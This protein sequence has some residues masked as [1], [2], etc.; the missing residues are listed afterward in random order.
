MAEGEEDEEAV[1]ALLPDEAVLAEVGEHERGE[2]QC[3]GERCRRLPG[4]QGQAQQ[5]ECGEHRGECP[6]G[7]LHALH[8]ASSVE[9]ERHPQAA[10]HEGLAQQR[11][12]PVLVGEPAPDA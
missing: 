12:D 9:V 8:R 1:A 10:A 3:G 4:D 5:G 6:A 11:A 2:Q 7:G